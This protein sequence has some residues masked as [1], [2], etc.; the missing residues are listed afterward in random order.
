MKKQDPRLDE[1]ALRS[2]GADK[3]CRIYDNGG[4]TADRYTVVYT[5]RYRNYTGGVFLYIGMSEHPC[6]PQGFGQHGESPTQ[7]DV[8]P[9]SYGGPPVGKTCH[10]GRRI[11]FRDLPNDCKDLVIRELCN[12][13]S[14]VKKASVYGR[15]WPSGGI[16]KS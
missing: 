3:L 1:V 15:T 16:E 2:G 5:G 9:G 4:R 13:W 12:I 6:H 11:L 7:I 10:L 8:R 14:L